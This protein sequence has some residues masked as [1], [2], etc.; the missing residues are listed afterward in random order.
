MFGTVVEKI[1]ALLSR[2][3]LLGSFFPVLVFFVLNVAIMGL[4]IDKISDTIVKGWPSTPTGVSTDL[5]FALIGLAIVAFVLAPV[6]PIFRT[7]IEDAKLLPA[8]AR[9]S[10]LDKHAKR[11]VV[12][13]DGYT[14]ASKRVTELKMAFERAQNA[15]D[16]AG[17]SVGAS[18]KADP[19]STFNNAKQAVAKL[20]TEIQDLQKQEE[21]SKRIPMQTTIDNAISA[22]QGAFRQNTVS[23]GTISSDELGLLNFGLM[24]KL[25]EL[26]TLAYQSLQDA[27]AHRR[28]EFGN[29]SV[30]P[31]RLANSRAAMENYSTVAYNVSFNFLWPR[32]R[33]V[34]PK[35]ATITG[36]VEIATAE[37]DFAVL[38]TF[39]S[40]ATTVIWLVL[41]PIFG[42]SRIVYFAVAVLGP[43]F[44]LFFY[45]LVCAAQEAFRAVAET[46]IDG[47]RFE[48]L[49]ALHL[50]LPT[51][52]TMEQKAWYELELAIYSAADSEIRYR[53]P[54]P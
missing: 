20:E 30:R 26:N 19:T 49:R 16:P 53:H 24:G 28:S 14:A 12:L 38:M 35:D 27:D 3:F 8:K 29:G 11:L 7:M 23:P 21:I 47:W 2:S 25:N 15:S 46:A 18:N 51:S 40:F 31:T 54:K 39:L 43:A 13:D 6:T 41:L 22:V 33:M 37:L 4:G 50:P 48:V 52:L 9:E 5:A 42:T 10:L 36:A 45:D 17:N 34:L 32:L 44:V 1:Q